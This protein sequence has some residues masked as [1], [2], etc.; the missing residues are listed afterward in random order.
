MGSQAG[1]RGESSGNG[2]EPIAGWETKTP[3]R[4]NEIVMKEKGT[5]GGAKISRV[6]FPRTSQ[7]MIFGKTRKSPGP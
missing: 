5:A 3:I 6:V 2:R 1:E 7:G 4:W